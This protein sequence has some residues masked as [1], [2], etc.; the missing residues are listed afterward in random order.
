MI[1]L[2][3]T[4][5]LAHVQDSYLERL[6]SEPGF[7]LAESR[8]IVHNRLHDVFPRDRAGRVLELGCGPGKYLPMLAALGHTV[9]G[10]DPCEFP[11]WRSIEAHGLAKTQSG[12][13]AES[14]PFA[15]GEFD[16]VACLGALLYFEDPALSLREMY[17]VLKPGGRLLLR[18]VNSG[19]L[20]TKRTGKKLD[21]G[22]R[23]LYTMA[24]L[25][26]LIRDVDFVIDERWS[27]G[28]WP[29]AFTNLWWY[30]V[31]VFVPDSLQKAFS[32]W[33]DPNSRVV[34]VVVAHKPIFE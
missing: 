3:M 8:S 31:C 24:E 12:V 15:D 27:F 20:Y 14:L 17:R 22:S 11:A 26:T 10:V 30:C 18:T 21:P 13:M 5:H 16:H 6:I 4:R 7:A 28:Y 32:D 33:T 1:P 9:I 2:W 29:P 34:N 25:E 19:N 23:N